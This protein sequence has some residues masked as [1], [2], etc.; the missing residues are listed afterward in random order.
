MGYKGGPARRAREPPGQG[1]RA[2]PRG[3]LTHF[4]RDPANASAAVGVAHASR[5][6]E[7]AAQGLERG[8][9]HVPTVNRHAEE[10]AQGLERGALAFGAMGASAAVGV[11][12]ADRHAKEEAQGLKRGALL[13]ARRSGARVP[14]RRSTRYHA[15]ANRRG[16]GGGEEVWVLQVRKGGPA[17]RAAQRVRCRQGQVLRQVQ[18]DEKERAADSDT[19]A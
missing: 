11:A 13:A 5:H 19:S 7:E 1:G 15:G 9:L 2:E 4:G 12:I 16:E 17:G 3:A 10:A 14:R 6:A 8:A 18:A